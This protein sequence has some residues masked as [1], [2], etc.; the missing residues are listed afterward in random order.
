MTEFEILEKKLDRAITL[1]ER[2]CN[3]IDPNPGYYQ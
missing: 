2:L 3:V 1:L